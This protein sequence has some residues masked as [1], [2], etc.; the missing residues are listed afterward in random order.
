MRNVLFS[1]KMHKNSSNSCA[2]R[3]IRMLCAD[4]HVINTICFSI[5]RTI[6]DLLENG[7]LPKV[8]FRFSPQFRTSPVV[9]H[10]HFSNIWRM[11]L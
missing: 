1:I 10:K 4:P 7:Q 5:I 3:D 2:C 11:E 6:G 9:T 8:R